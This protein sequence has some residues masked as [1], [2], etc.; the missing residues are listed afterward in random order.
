MSE[1]IDWEAPETA[2]ACRLLFRERGEDEAPEAFMREYARVS[3]YGHE[4]ARR[5]SVD[6][7][8]ASLYD[9]DGRR[10]SGSGELQRLAQQRA[11]AMAEKRR[12]WSY[13]PLFPASD[14]SRITWVWMASTPSRRRERRAWAVWDRKRRARR[15]R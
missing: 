4:G 9:Q 7:T 12:A 14:P 8:D 11:R 2:L 15:K 13:G 10:I 5:V 6:L 1:L 3:P